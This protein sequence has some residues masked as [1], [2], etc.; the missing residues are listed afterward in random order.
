MHCICK[1]TCVWER[2]GKAMRRWEAEPL[3]VSQPFC[4]SS[5]LPSSILWAPGKRKSRNRPPE[6]AG[7]LW[8]PEIPGNKT[9]ALGSNKQYAVS[10]DFYPLRMIILTA[11]KR[12]VY[13]LIW[14]TV[15]GIVPLPPQWAH[16]E[17]V[18]FSE[19]CA[20]KKKTCIRHVSGPQPSPHPTW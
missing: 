3:L 17:A 2:K 10:M 14:A 20:G 19:A 1:H 8:S 5:C 12:L 6:E 4:L 11:S 9:E 7:L 16:G 13:I 15:A 18:P